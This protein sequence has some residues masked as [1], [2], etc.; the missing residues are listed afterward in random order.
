MIAPITRQECRNDSPGEKALARCVESVQTLVQ[1]AVQYPAPSTIE[2]IRINGE[3]LR[4]LKKRKEKKEGQS[5]EH[6]Q[7]Q[8]RGDM[9]E[10]IRLI[11]DLVG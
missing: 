1:G 4:S 3:R 7:L 6:Q 9:V 11:V 2:P 10:C 8:L 5:G